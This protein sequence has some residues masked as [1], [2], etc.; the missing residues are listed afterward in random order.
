MTNDSDDP[1]D[2]MGTGGG[3]CKMDRSYEMIMPSQNITFKIFMFEGMSGNYERENHWHRSLEIFAVFSGEIDFWLGDKEY[4]LTSGDFMLV[5]SNVVHR[6]LAEKENEVVVLQI[7][8]S[9][10][11]K[12][13]DAE[14]FIFFTY[15]SKIYDEDTMVLIH[16][17]YQTY[18]Q[19]EN[20]YEFKVLSLFYELMY[21]LADKYREKDISP[22]IVKN[23]KKLNKL[24]EI[25][26]YIKR[27]YN[28]ELTL[29]NLAEMFGYTSV[30]LSR[31]FKK[32][33]KISYKVY[34]DN[35][36]L[37][38]AVKDLNETDLPIERIA[39]KH[40]FANG[41]AFA[42]TFKSRYGSSPRKYRNENSKLK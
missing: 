7:P 28:Q 42:Q 9:V 27:N 19:K 8:Y 34:L 36:R 38:H 32:Y 5:N 30:H 10:F 16:D 11:E 6:I 33:M 40:G 26:D 17:I 13:Y 18:M 12:Y 22:K 15:S 35:L 21:I 4:H 2:E 37:K 20:A 39:E 3:G 25:I 1:K 29:E 23:A 41:R 24:T 31:M 14:G